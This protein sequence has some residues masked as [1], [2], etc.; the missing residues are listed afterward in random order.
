MIKKIKATNKVSDSRNL[1]NSNFKELDKRLKE[2]EDK[3]KIKKI[4]IEK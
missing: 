1:I 2:L 3:L 4:S